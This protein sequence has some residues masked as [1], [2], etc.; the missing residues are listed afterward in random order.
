MQN[1]SINWNKQV[2]KLKV[3]NCKNHSIMKLVY[4]PTFLN[5]E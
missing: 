2:Q 4:L 1:N 3:N 5:G